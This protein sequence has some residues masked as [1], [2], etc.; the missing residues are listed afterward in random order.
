MNANISLIRYFPKPC[1][2]HPSVRHGWMAPCFPA[3]SMVVTGCLMSNLNK[4]LLQQSRWLVGWFVVGWL[5]PRDER[6]KSPVHPSKCCG[7]R[8]ATF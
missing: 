2:F 1:V 6:R 8:G 3:A 5:Q 4:L 7:G